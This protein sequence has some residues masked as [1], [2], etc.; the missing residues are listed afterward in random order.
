[1]TTPLILT[2]AAY[3]LLALL[4][5][6]VNLAS[7]WRWWIK[8]GTIVITLAVF[9]A[10]YFIISGMAGWPTTEPL[11]ARFALLNTQVLDP[12]KIN[13]KPGAIYLWVQ[14]ID[15]TQRPISPPRAYELPY[16]S[17]MLKTVS[18]GQDQLDKGEDVLGTAASVQSKDSNGDADG[19]EG[20][21][22]ARDGQGDS[23]SGNKH[24]SGAAGAAGF[25][26]GQ[27]V[28][29]GA[30]PPPALP[31]KAPIQP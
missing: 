13:N 9:A 18:D 27:S 29:F 26:G 6:S 23:A 24:G 16:S 3:G 22:Q 17:G 30:M 8:A 20:T 31:T 12:D 21:S 2:V 19:S 28:S 4:L 11:P 7:R 25:E 15:D 10:S 5:L 1:M 14:E